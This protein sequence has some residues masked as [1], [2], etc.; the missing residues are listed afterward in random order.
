MS[1]DNV[2]DVPIEI[3]P[4]LDEI[5]ERLVSGH[6]VVMVG[7]GFSKNASLE[8][9]D[10]NQLGD[11]FYHKVC[12]V[13]PTPGARYLNPLKLA[14]EVQAAFGRPALDQLLRDNIPDKECEPSELHVKLLKLPWVDVFTT[15]YDTLLERA[16]VSVNNQRFDVVVNKED[17]V[18]ATKPRIVK[19]HGSFPS[20][21]PF[22]ITEEDYRKYPRINAPFVNTV[23]QALIENTLCMIGFSGEDP[24]F[25]QWIGWI[26]DNLGKDNS[27]TIFL[28][29][30][31]SLS[32]AQARLLDERNITVINMGLCPSAKDDHYRALDLFLSYLDSKK[33]A[34]NLLD[35]PQTPSIPPGSG[36]T[37]LLDA[38]RAQ[39]GEYPNW[40]ILPEDKR[41]AMLQSIQT[42]RPHTLF[43]SANQPPTDIDF[44]YELNWRLER[45]LCPVPNEY[46]PHYERII[47]LYNPFPEQIVIKPATITPH[48]LEIAGLDWKDISFK[49]T[50]L[51]L[52]LLR[53][54]REE[55]LADKWKSIDLRL[56]A[57][58]GL[59]LPEQMAQWHYERC[60]Y[61]L[62]SF[63]LGAL[64]RELSDWP[65][66][67]SLPFWEAKRAGL[68]A[69]LG[70]IAEA[71]RILEKALAL[72]RKNQQLSPV[73]RDYT[74]VSQESLMMIVLH[75]VKLSKS[76]A[77]ASY[78]EIPA[79]RQEFSTRWDSLRQFRCD[80][81]NDLELFDIRL[82]APVQQTRSV[83]RTKG[84][85]IGRE[86]V[87]YHLEQS[88]KEAVT[89]YAFLT[90]QR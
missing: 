6:G 12:G 47:D 63:D 58:S 7:S 27:P 34:T 2:M 24:N 77:A 5:A 14:D 4:Y 64:K 8:F 76:F 69:E 81:W 60:L 15:N 1:Q 41:Q 48:I 31:F 80:P 22:V 44:L 65:V 17:L 49:W 72:V 18:Y 84:F 90:L 46:I 10:W 78:K 88:D 36:V 23:Q 66:N 54:F 83:T 42:Q 40:V 29:G 55:C 57:L 79:I 70:D 35:W 21:R 13:E 75:A 20:E 9:P 3:Q 11:I 61:W 43:A 28:V 26:R 38:W 30:L 85:D 86:H 82:S 45:T 39:R 71:E 16:R 37:Q 51:N 32:T 59:F 67:D 19:L 50:Q 33:R 74:W 62:F 56:A 53:Y 73:V 89:A 52:A 87:Q 25:L 68:V